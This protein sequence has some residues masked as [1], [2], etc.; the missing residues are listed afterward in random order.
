M[1]LGDPMHRQRQ[2]GPGAFGVE[3]MVPE[4]LD[5]VASDIT[6]I[7]V[8]AAHRHLVVPVAEHVDRGGVRYGGGSRAAG[9]GDLACAG[10]QRSATGLADSKTLR[11]RGWR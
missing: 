7:A 10:Q 5:P 8:R 1:Q 9:E 6:R 2:D 4:L 11:T 3:P